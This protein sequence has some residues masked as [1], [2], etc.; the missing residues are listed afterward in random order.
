[1]QPLVQIANCDYAILT[2]ANFVEVR[3]RRE[4]DLLGLLKAEVALP[5]VSIR[6]A[7]VES[8]LHD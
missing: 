5:A 8:D 2:V 1:M 7:W 4:I 6:L 3:S